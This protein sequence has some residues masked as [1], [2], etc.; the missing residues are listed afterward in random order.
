MNFTCAGEIEG[1][2]VKG[3]EQGRLDE[4]ARGAQDRALA[5]PRAQGHWWGGL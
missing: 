5:A 3:E 4:A 2:R 1:A